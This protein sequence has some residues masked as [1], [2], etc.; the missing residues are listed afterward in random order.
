LLTNLRA[1]VVLAS[2]CTAFQAC[3]FNLGDLAAKLQQLSQPQGP[4]AS[5]AGTRS[6][7]DW[8]DHVCG[9]V[10]GAPYE[11]V[12]LRA[13]PADLI[14]RYFAVG[15]PTAFEQ[16]LRAGVDRTHQGTLISLRLHVKD[17]HDKKI[18]RLAEAFVQNPSSDMLAQVMHFAEH[19][20]R[21]FEEGVGSEW[22]EAQTLLAMVLMQ[23]PELIRDRGQVMRLLRNGDSQISQSNLA[24]ALMARAFLFGD[25]ATASFSDFDGRIVNPNPTPDARLRGLTIEW[26]IANVPQWNRRQQYEQQMRLARD[27]R[28]VMSSAFG[29]QRTPASIAAASQRASVLLDQADDVNRLTGDALGVGPEIAQIQARIE[30]VKREST[31]E[32]NLVQV[33]AS[34]TAESSAMLAAATARRPQLESQAREKLVRANQLRA[35]HLTQLRRYMVELAVMAIGGDVTQLEILTAPMGTLHRSSCDVG[36]RTLQFSEKLGDPVPV[37]DPKTVSDADFGL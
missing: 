37:V 20:D 10:Y 2:L 14:G 21:Y 17:L 25:Y 7:S 1:W 24:K 19:G 32:Q 28:G 8:F 11:R 23:Y 12:P 4:S 27:M 5:T 31:G 22:G 30:Q 18:R 9:S 13:G 33:R 15:D 29:A 16:K 35:D 36:Y 26:A 3:A 34:I 6:P